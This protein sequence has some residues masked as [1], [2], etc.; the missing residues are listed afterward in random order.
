MWEQ[1]QVVG[2]LI[3]PLK[4]ETFCYLQKK[5]EIMMIEETSLRRENV[6]N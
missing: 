3:N 2:I 1:E 4:T 5:F 6:E